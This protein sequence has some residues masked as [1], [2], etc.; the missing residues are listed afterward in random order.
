VEGPDLLEGSDAVLVGVAAAT[1]HLGAGRRADEGE[2]LAS[3]EGHSMD[4]GEDFVA[5]Q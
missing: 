3:A 1:F 5:A 4:A 2:G